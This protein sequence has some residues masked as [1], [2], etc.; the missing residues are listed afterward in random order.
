MNFIKTVVFLAIC[1]FALNWMY[2]NQSKFLGRTP[3]VS[4]NGFV[5]LPEL[6][7]GV[8]GKVVVFAP[9]NCPSD[10]AARADAMA[11]NLA[12]R[13][14]PSV[15]SHDVQFSSTD[16]DPAIA[17]RLNAVMNGD[18]PIVLVNGKGKANPTFEEVLAEYKTAR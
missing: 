7:G 18:L 10:A 8:S 5:T 12:Y 15:R 14:I 9:E 3:V 2:T 17:A 1:G 4:A 13:N 6:T 16:P 11:Q